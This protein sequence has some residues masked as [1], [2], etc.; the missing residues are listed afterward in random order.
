MIIPS[1]KLLAYF[2]TLTFPIPV[3]EEQSDRIARSVNHTELLAL[4]AKEQVIGVGNWKRIKRLRLNRPL[5]ASALAKPEK[6]H[7]SRATLNARTNLG[8]RREQLNEVIVRED[9]YGR[10]VESEGERRGWCYSFCLLNGAFNKRSGMS[11]EFSGTFGQ[12]AR[13]PDL[14]TQERLA[15]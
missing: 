13:K 3:F 1:R 12:S 15:S 10:R 5:E 6:Q 11:Q 9:I 14:E 2:P 8:V 7:K 4:V